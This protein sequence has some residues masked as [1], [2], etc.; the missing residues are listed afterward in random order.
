MVA[1][2]LFAG[3][4]TLRWNA[5]DPADSITV[6][7]SVPVVL[8]AARFGLRG[9]LAAALFAFALTA[10]WSAALDVGLGPLAFTARLGAFLAAGVAV[11]LVAERV[12]RMSDDRHRLVAVSEEAMHRSFQAEQFQI[13]TSLLSRAVTQEQVAEAYVSEGLRLFGASRGAVFVLND[14]RT[15][16]ET[17]AVFRLEP[18]GPAP[19]AEPGAATELDARGWTTLPLRRPTPPTDAVRTGEENFQHDRDEIIAAYPHL[20]GGRALGDDQAWGALPLVGRDGPVGAIVVSF[21]APHEFYP[22]ERE[23]FRLVARRVC[24]AMERAQLLERAGRERARAE[25]SERRASLLA[26]IGAVLTSASEPAE[27]M[28]RL[29]DVLVPAFADFGT[30]EEVNGRWLELLAAAHVDPVRLAELRSLRQRYSLAQGD[31]WSL[32]HAVRTGKA[33]LLA[34]IPEDLMARAGPNGGAAMATM[35]ALRPYSAL[36]L[37]LKARGM[38]IGGLLLGQSDSRRVFNRADLA[39]AE[40]IAGRA[41]LALD[42]AQL[43]ERQRDVSATLQH[44]LLPEVLPQAPGVMAAARYRPGEASLD[45]GG[46]WYDVISLPYD[47][48]GIV[49]GDVVGRGVAA[50]ATMGQLRSAVAAIAPYCSGPAELLRRLDSF[51]GSVAGARLATAAYAEFEPAVGCLRYACAGHPPP[52]LIVDGAVSFLTGGR[53]VPMATG[54]GLPWVQDEIVIEDHATLVCYS[55]GLVEQRGTTVDARLAQLAETTAGLTGVSL[56][57]LCDELIVR[58]I[59]GSPLDDDVALLCL[60]L[61]RTSSANFREVMPA[62]RGRL[63]RLRSRL[64][65]WAVGVGL[66]EVQIADLL[67]ATGE[68]CA[69]AIEHAYLDDAEAGRIEIRAEH[70]SDGM[71]VA[72]VSDSGRWRAQ[73]H[74]GD[75]R[76]RGLALIWATMSAVEIDSRPSGTTVTMRMPGPASTRSVGDRRAG[77]RS[78]AMTLS[79]DRGAAHH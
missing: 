5:A 73:P 79:V 15:A 16:L 43:Y 47:R 13:L 62:D 74:V 35:A 56:E 76:G 59:G 58:M 68:A 26:D 51:A 7:Y 46:D 28:R 57:E 66:D 17:V 42:N 25:A 24:D 50:A 36:A 67:L 12:I 30:V 72:R 53:N 31:D 48:V 63:A 2:A 38:V 21:A 8:L 6:L 33:S 71:I 1:G 52:L 29:L 23:M 10:F 19:A 64:R 54:S 18:D 34:T 77:S 9:G 49:L 75:P 65:G 39:L 78:E 41:A 14:A 20:S 22:A 40:L 3:I 69:N 44:A 60:R 61:E 27:R 32:A 37:P 45:V 55:D 70:S 11:G 4:F